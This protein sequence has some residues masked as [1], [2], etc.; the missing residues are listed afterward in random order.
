MLDGPRLLELFVEEL[1]QALC[2]GQD[3]YTTVG[4][5]LAL[6]FASPGN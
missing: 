2:P 5:S 1:L 3:L 4:F 6:L